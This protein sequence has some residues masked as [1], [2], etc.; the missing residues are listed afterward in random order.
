[1]REFYEQLAKLQ[2]IVSITDF[3]INQTPEQTA[4]KTID[5]QFLLT[6]YYVSAERLQQQPPGSASAPAASVPPSSVPPPS[7]PKQ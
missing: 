1:L 6:A 3:K 2:R 7:A 4:N 5:A